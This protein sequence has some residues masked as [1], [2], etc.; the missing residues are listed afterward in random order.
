MTKSEALKE[1]TGVFS[2]FITFSSDYFLNT[3]HVLYFPSGRAV[4][5]ESVI[6]IYTER[7]ISDRGTGVVAQGMMRGR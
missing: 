5:E 1:N 6:F 2:G 3:L 4:T 7:M